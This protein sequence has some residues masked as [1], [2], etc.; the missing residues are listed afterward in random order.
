MKNQKCTK[1]LTLRTDELLHG[2]IMEFAK[3]YNLSIS[4]AIRFLIV[5]GLMEVASKSS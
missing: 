4:S 2:K 5:T 3:S 1:N